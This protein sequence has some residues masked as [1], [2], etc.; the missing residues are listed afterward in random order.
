MCRSIRM[1]VICWLCG[2]P[3]RFACSTFSSSTVEKRYALCYHLSQTVQWREGMPYA[4][5][6]LRQYS[7][8]KVCLMLS[9]RPPV[10]VALCWASYL[11]FTLADF[12]SSRIQS[13]C[14]SNKNLCQRE[15]WQK[16]LSNHVGL[17]LLPTE[18]AKV[19]STVYINS[20]WK[21]HK[22]VVVY[23]LVPSFMQ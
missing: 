17:I 10:T 4:I 9:S 22:S 13:T 5:V 7:G 16:F 18:L 6:Y 3:T 20:N 11:L 19:N 21:K 14:H 2:Y 15:C 8:E 1:I 23:V 12:F